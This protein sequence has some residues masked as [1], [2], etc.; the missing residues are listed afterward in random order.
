M[1]ILAKGLVRFVAG[2]LRWAVPAGFG[3]GRFLWAHWVDQG[4]V[5][6]RLRGMRANKTSYER[7]QRVSAILA[8]RFSGKSLADIGAEEKPAI[9]PQAVQQLIGRALAVIPKQST[10][11]IRLLEAGRLDAMQNALW[12]RCLAGDIGAINTALR[13]MVRRAAMLGLDL[14]PG[15]GRE[16]G[17]P[18]VVRVE[19]IGNPEI[20]RVRWL[21]AERE[22]LLAL[23]EGSALPSTTLN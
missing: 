1:L 4:V 19:I 20:E 22:R 23:T 7:M 10:D 15:F 8:K 12:E 17:D 13:I 16:D 6:R 14:Q 2:G 9:S 3:A 21:E 18:G 11:Q 5:Q